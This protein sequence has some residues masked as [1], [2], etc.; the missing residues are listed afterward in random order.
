MHQL[1]DRAALDSMERKRSRSTAWFK[2]LSMHPWFDGAFT[3][4][5]CRRIPE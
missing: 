3:R 4:T 2:R 1:S 5:L